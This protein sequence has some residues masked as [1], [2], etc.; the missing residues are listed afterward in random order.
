MVRPTVVPLLGVGV[1]MTLVRSTGPVGLQSSDG[2]L[3]VRKLAAVKF[4][5]GFTRDAMV[6]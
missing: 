2:P 1:E 3:G 5:G 4:P 6:L